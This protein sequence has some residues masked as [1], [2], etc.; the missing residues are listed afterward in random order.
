MC[1]IRLTVTSG[2]C[3]ALCVSALDPAT[4]TGERPTGVMGYDKMVL[5]RRGVKGTLY[6]NCDDACVVAVDGK[7]VG[8]SS[9]R[10]TARA[11]LSLR[12]GSIIT[13]HCRDTC[14][15]DGLA[16]VFVSSDG[17]ASFATGPDGWYTYT[18]TEA[19][20]WTDLA[21][22]AATDLRPCRKGTNDAW[23]LS[24]E[25]ASGAP[26]PQSIWASNLDTTVYIVHVV[27]YADLAAK[28]GK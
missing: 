16:L 27:T 13:A 5:E 14:T 22:V 7:V 15:S 28:G 20:A 3:L 17:K 11:E 9:G 21:K 23:R 6:F 26:C 1:R 4:L 25:R 8:S 24:L 12:L 10:R 2:L 18:P 19:T